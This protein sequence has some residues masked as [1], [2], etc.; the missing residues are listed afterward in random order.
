[1]KIVGFD[2]LARETI[3]DTLVAENIKY[4]HLAKIMCDALNAALCK[5]DSAPV[6]Y[7]V[8]PDDY[9]LSRGMEDLV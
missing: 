6:Y 3:P 9:R 1:M 2:N 4:D 8:V 5:D 7:R